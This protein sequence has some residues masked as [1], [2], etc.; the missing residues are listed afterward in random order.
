LQLGV[1][2]CIAFFESLRKKILLHSVKK[3]E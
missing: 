2:F 3:E 1:K